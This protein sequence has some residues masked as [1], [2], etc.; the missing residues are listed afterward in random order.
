MT[1]IRLAVI[2]VIVIL[3]LITLWLYWKPKPKA[4]KPSDDH[5]DDHHDTHGPS[6]WQRMV[7]GTVVTVGSVAVLLLAISAFRC[8]SAAVEKVRRPEPPR[9]IV[10]AP[11]EVRVPVRECLT[12]CSHDIRWKFEIRARRGVKVKWP[13]AGWVEYADGSRLEP[14]DTYEYGET[15]F[16]SLDDEP[17]VIEIFRKEYR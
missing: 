14:P 1:G 15:H 17:V 3:G 2:L 11:V 7:E 6:L 13:K 12:P 5:S 8:S 10:A 16:A 4:D 9:P